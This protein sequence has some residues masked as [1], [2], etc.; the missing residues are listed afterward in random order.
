MTNLRK[1]ELSFGLATLGMAFL[2]SAFLLKFDWDASL[3]VKKEFLVR[4]ELLVVLLLFLIPGALGVCRNNQELKETGYPKP[5]E[6][7]E[8]LVRGQM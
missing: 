8:K 3:I 4:R 5:F 6:A 1:L 2:L 7:T